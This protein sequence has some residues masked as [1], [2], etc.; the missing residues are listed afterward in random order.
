MGLGC[1]G[2]QCAASVGGVET[3]S[4]RVGDREPAGRGGRCRSADGDAEGAEATPGKPKAR[5]LRRDVDVN[6][7]ARPSGAK[8]RAVELHPSETTVG[9]ERGRDPR[10]GSASGEHGQD[11]RRPERRARSESLDDLATWRR[12]ERDAG[13]AANGDKLLSVVRE[14]VDTGGPGL[15]RG[16]RSIRRAR[17]RRARWSG[18]GGPRRSAARASRG[19]G[20]RTGARGFRLWRPLGNARRDGHGDRGAGGIGVSIRQQ[21]PHAHHAGDREQAGCPH[22]DDPGIATHPIRPLSRPTIGGGC[23]RHGR[24]QRRGRDSNPRESF[25]PLLA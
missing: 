10:P 20:V 8:A 24:I 14:P 18:L 12:A 2:R 19:P 16:G 23:D 21:R 11:R 5:D 9:T 7:V 22:R 4:K 13:S 3:A 25:R 1:A 15:Y 17:R 6:R